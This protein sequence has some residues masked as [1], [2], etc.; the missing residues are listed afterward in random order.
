MHANTLTTTQ[1]ANLPAVGEA[2]MADVSGVLV[3][4]TM[5]KLTESR[6]RVLTTH[7]GF[8]KVISVKTI[9]RGSK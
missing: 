8:P 4:A 7:H 3:P 6:W 9:I 5:V 2:V 1:R